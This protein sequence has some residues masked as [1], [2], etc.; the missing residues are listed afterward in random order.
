MH[1]LGLG[2]PDRLPEDGLDAVADPAALSAARGLRAPRGLAVG[3]QQAEPVGGHSL[4]Q[5]R[6]PVV[7]VADEVAGRPRGQSQG[8][9][10]RGAGGRRRREAGDAPRPRRQGVAAE[11][12]AGSGSA[13]SWPCRFRAQGTRRPPPPSAPRRRP[14]ADQGRAA[15][16]GGRRR[17]APPPH[18]PGRRRPQSGRPGPR[19]TPT[20]RLEAP[21]MV[22]RPAALV[23]K[24]AHGV[25]QPPT[26]PGPLTLFGEARPEAPAVGEAGPAAGLL[27]RRANGAGVGAEQ[28]GR[29]VAPS[30]HLRH[31][32]A[33]PVSCLGRHPRPRPVQ[34]RCAILRSAPGQPVKRG[35]VGR[36]LAALVDS[37]RFGQRRNPCGR[38]SSSPSRQA[39]ATAS[40]SGVGAQSGAGARRGAC[41]GRSVVARRSWGHRWGRKRGGASA[42]APTPRRFGL[43]EPFVPVPPQGFEP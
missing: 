41:R 27:T 24:L 42:E 12:E 37:P 25:T 40:C 11:A 28:D 30:P 18:R 26:P 38:S 5:P 7:A 33:A 2:A 21:P 36:N 34:Q 1:A 29:T 23:P 3:G 31:C 15:A 13:R 6:R 43:D 35:M 4:G 20:G 17:G 9:F 16:S 8:D 10:R 14:A 22:G 19:G 39:C 32:L